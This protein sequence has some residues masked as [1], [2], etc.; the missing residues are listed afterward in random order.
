MP[1]LA[2]LATSKK[3]GSRHYDY[4][5]EDVELTQ[6]GS[7]GESILRL[8]QDGFRSRGD[9][10]QY[11]HDSYDLTGSRQYSRQRTQ[12]RVS[13]PDTGGLSAVFGMHANTTRT[14]G[15]ELHEPPP[16]NSDTTSVSALVRGGRD[17]ILSSS[18]SGSTGMRPA[19][20]L[21]V[22]GAQTKAH[23][24]TQISMSMLHQ[25]GDLPP[26]YEDVR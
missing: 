3:R 9:R 16:S 18:A 6:R 13:E 19:L 21:L 26:A 22:P 14:G 11:V 2:R 10:T 7:H 1:I 5:T 20:D 25:G 12:V 17:T 23:S 4:V 24:P 8:A 15:C